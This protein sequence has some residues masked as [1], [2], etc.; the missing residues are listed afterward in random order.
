MRVGHMEVGYRLL[1]SEQNEE[2]VCVSDP[3]Q[4]VEARVR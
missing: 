1:K 2:D 3:T 4:D